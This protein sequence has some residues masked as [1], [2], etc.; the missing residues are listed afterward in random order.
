MITHIEMTDLPLMPR[1]EV[2]RLLE[3]DEAFRYSV[4]NRDVENMRLV[5]RAHGYN[6]STQCAEYAVWFGEQELIQPGF[7]DVRPLS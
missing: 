2:A 7:N 5:L 6:Y 3:T 1:S 4:E